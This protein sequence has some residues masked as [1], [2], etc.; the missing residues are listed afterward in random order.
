MI[1]CSEC[2]KPI[3]ECICLKTCEICAG[4]WCEDS[5]EH[6]TLKKYKKIKVAGEIMLKNICE[7]IKIF[8]AVFDEN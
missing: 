5:A 3:L 4:C 7:S 1:P 6:C 8:K 2:K